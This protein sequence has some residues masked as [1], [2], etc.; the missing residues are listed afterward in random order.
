[1]G[2][3]RL[4]GTETIALARSPYGAGLAPRAGKAFVYSDCWV[5]DSRLVVL[6]ARDA[7]DR[8]AIVRTRTR[9]V[10]A[11]REDAHWVATIEQ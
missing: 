8:G 2:R 7:A 5:A 11:R 4:P 9:L 6:N 10:S 1:G 3:K